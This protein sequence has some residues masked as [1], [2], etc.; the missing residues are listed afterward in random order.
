MERAVGLCQSVL[1]PAPCM[2]V[3][4]LLWQVNGWHFRD[5]R[6]AALG[7]RLASLAAVTTLRFVKFDGW[8]ALGAL[9]WDVSSPARFQPLHV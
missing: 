5:E 7:P 3:S 9:R 1:L 4:C 8:R 2:N 6:D